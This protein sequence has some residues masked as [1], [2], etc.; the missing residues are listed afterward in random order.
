MSRL[1]SK[2]S[3]FPETSEYD[4]ASRNSVPHVPAA[5]PNHCC[6]PQDNTETPVEPPA[7]QGDHTTC[8]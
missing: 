8:G 4:K 3:S 7:F 6:N 2:Q 1:E 5:D